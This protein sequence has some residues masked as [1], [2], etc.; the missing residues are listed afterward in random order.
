MFNA[1]IEIKDTSWMYKTIPDIR[2]ATWFISP[3]SDT[4]GIVA[5][6][7]EGVSIDHLHIAAS[8]SRVRPTLNLSTQVKIIS[9]T[10]SKNNPYQLS[11]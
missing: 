4:N 7:R 9:G 10:G 2:A 11:L 3:T 1:D 6:F 5:A 8:R